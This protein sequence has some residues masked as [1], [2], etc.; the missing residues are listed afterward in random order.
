MKVEALNLPNTSLW[1]LDTR[2][3]LPLRLFRVTV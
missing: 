3:V 2:S 1:S